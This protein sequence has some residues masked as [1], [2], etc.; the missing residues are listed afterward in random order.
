M[1][2]LEVLRIVHKNP[3]QIDTE[4]IAAMVSPASVS[5]VICQDS[6]TVELHSSKDSDEN[7]DT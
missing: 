2:D 3:G 1:A 6:N 5:C 7:K 4:K